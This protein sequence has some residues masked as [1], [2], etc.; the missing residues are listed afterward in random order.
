MLKKG[1]L[2]I[3]IIVL[4]CS[5]LEFSVYAEESFGTDILYD[6]VPDSAQ[7]YLVEN[8]IESDGNGITNLSLV[9]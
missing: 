6:T 3:S 9:M 1:F 2:I 7:E 4:F 8:G 5:F